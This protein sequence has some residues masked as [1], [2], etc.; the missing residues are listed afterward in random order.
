[1]VYTIEKMM[2]KYGSPMVLV[3]DDKALPFKGFLQHSGSKSWQ[4]M[5][6]QYCPA[7]RIPAGQ[8]VLLAPVVPEVA[9]GDTLICGDLQVTVQRVETVMAGEK[10]L[11]RWGLCVRKG[12][13]EPWV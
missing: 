9:E 4:N 12:G 10:L 11:Y 8:Y 13:G 1:M 3:R 6:V 2:R 5:R 7:G